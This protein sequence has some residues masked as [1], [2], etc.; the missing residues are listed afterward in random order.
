[1][2]TSQC[3]IGPLLAPFLPEPMLRVLRALAAFRIFQVTVEGTVA[4][5]S[6]SRLLR[7]DTPNS[8]HYAAR[9]CTGPG[10][11]NAWG[12]LDVAMKGGIPYEAA[13]NMDRLTYLRPHPDEA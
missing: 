1:M 11:W 10:S 5:T 2:A 12:M 4:H 9:F 8:M 3:K 6:R 7:T 13:W